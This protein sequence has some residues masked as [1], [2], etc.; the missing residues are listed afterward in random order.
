V[1]LNV[2]H[3][4]YNSDPGH[5][6]RLLAITT[7][8]LMLQLFGSLRLIN[9]MPFDFKD[10]YDGSPDYFKRTK[11]IEK[12]WDETNFVTCARANS[13]NGPSAAG[14]PQHL[15]EDGRADDPRAAR[16]GIR[17]GLVQ[18]WPPASLRSDH[19]DVQRRRVFAGGQE[20]AGR[21]AVG[22][23]GLAGRT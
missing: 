21:I 20:W 16:I 14:R 9:E 2:L 22:E 11:R 10:R 3:R 6:A 23:A 8:P 4:H 18:A 17:S 13:R 12:R 5:P 15:L 1:P 19:S 7:F